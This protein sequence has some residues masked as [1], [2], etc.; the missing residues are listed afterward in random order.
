MLL[1]AWSKQDNE[2]QC[3]TMQVQR[4][5]RKRKHSQNA[6]APAGTVNSVT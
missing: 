2:N 3:Q 4:V 1:E 6:K 5:S